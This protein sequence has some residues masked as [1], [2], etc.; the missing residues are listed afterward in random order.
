MHRLLRRLAALA[1]AVP[2]LSHAAFQPPR[3]ATIAS[4]ALGAEREVDV[5]LPA[6]DANGARHDTIYVLDGDWNAAQ[7]VRTIEFVQAVGLMPAVVVVGVRNR[8]EGGANRRDQDFTP[9]TV[10]T[11]PGSGGADRFLAFLR[12]ELVPYVDSRYPTNGHRLAHGHSYGGLFLAHVLG[13]EPTL[14]DDYALLDPAAWWDRGVVVEPL[15][16]ALKRIDPHGR[17]L[18]IAGREGD[19][20]ETMGLHRLEATLH[21]DAPP[22]LHWAMRA[23]ADETHDSLKF[24]ATYDALRFAYQGYDPHRV[25]LI[26]DSGIVVAGRPVR[27][28]S[29]DERFPLRWTM[30]GSTP[31]PTSPLADSRPIEEPWRL[32]VRLVSNSGRFDRELPLDLVA[33]DAFPPLPSPSPRATDGWRHASVGA[34]PLPPRTPPTRRVRGELLTLDASATYG[35][36]LRRF[37]VE[38]DGYHVIAL[39]SPGRLRLWID[40]R[41]V[42]DND[43]ADGRSQRTYLAPLDAGLHELRVDFERPRDGVVAIT[44]LPYGDGSGRW[45][46]APSAHLEIR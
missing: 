45:W 39:A 11:Q 25:D 4:A 20:W 9:T 26:P 15:A 34:W 28:G 21:R 1:C 35:V 29:T 37:R 31:G 19:A 7:V 14:F 27:L 13:R 32:R 12:D 40:G 43:G 23:Y 30:D 5:W 17:T 46:D 8:V 33:G 3:H 36:V 10:A 18:Y 44:L 38:Q 16:R 24:K 6:D 42:L 22:G 41:P 2:L